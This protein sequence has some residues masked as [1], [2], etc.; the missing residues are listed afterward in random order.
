MDIDIHLPSV[1]MPR[2][3][4]MHPERQ[5]RI[6]L[7]KAK[8]Q[9]RKIIRTG[10]S[11]RKFW[12]DIKIKESAFTSDIRLPFE[13]TTA[14]VSSLVGGV[15][16]AKG[17]EKVVADGESLWL[18]LSKEMI[19]LDNSKK[20]QKTSTRQY[21]T[22]KGVTLH[23]Q[24][25]IESGKYPRRHKLA[26]KTE[27]RLGLSSRLEVGKWYLHVHQVKILNPELGTRWLGTGRLIQRLKAVF[28]DAYYPRP[29]SS[30]SKAEFFNSNQLKS[31]MPRTVRENPVS[32][33]RGPLLL[34]HPNPFAP[35]QII[36]NPQQVSTKL[37]P[38]AQKQCFFPQ[39]VEQRI[40]YS[41][42]ARQ[43]MG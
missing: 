30:L 5:A 32:R 19:Y 34:S 7:H 21:W 15:D 43:G 27:D 1:E 26:V 24:L 18:Q 33:K 8:K 23:Q 42:V 4:L 41:Q 36:K 12:S 16:I 39:P 3:S 37:I 13:Q 10:Q 35:W 14:H 6:N 11:H 2:L 9:D 40:R 31:A 38:E 28:G 22:V 17:Y 29:K 25:S 20:R